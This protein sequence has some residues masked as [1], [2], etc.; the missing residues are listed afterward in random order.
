MADSA[1]EAIIRTLAI[2][3]REV[4]GATGEFEQRDGMI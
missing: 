4:W 3:L 2:T 1:L